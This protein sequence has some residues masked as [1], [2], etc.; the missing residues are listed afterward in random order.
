MVIITGHLVRLMLRMLEAI[1]QSVSLVLV[2]FLPMNRI[3]K[4]QASIAL[5]KFTQ[6]LSTL[7]Q[8]SGIQFPK[9]GWLS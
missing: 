8:Q 9:M 1:L 6:I 4:F 5:N 2:S 3:M 7:L